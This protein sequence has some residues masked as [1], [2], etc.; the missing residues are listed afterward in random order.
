MKIK[1]IYNFKIGKE[2]CLL[3]FK[4]CYLKKKK[5]TFHPPETVINLAPKTWF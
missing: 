3:F 2:F 1:Y 5:K 4:Y